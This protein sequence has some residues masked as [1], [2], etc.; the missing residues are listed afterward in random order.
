MKEFSL[1][2]VTPDGEVYSGG[3]ESLSVYTDDGVVEILAD[4]V[5]YMASLGTGRTRVKISG[6][7]RYAATSGGFL[8]FSKNEATLV[9]TTFEFSDEIDLARAE[10]AKQK[11]EELITKAKDD[12]ALALAKAKLMRALNR[13]KVAKE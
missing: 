1:K 9:A 10:A 11:A 6:E 3:A 7:N 4:H 8:T 13:I 12:K 2:I 5:E